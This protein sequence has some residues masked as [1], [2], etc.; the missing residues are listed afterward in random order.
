[1]LK[2]IFFT[3]IVSFSISAAANPIQDG[4]ASHGYTRINLSPTLTEV[5]DELATMASS[6]EPSIM[7]ETWNA[8]LRYQ[9]DK[10]GVSDAAVWLSVIRGPEVLD[11]HILSDAVPKLNRHTQPT[12]MGLARRSHEGR[13][14]AVLV[15]LHQGATF[16]VT[17]PPPSKS[18]GD[19]G[20]ITISGQLSLG[21]FQP[22]AVIETPTGQV[23]RQPLSVDEARRF[24]LV[25][26]P[27]TTSSSFRVEL[28]A[29]NVSGPRVLNVLRVGNP[30][31]APLL[32]IIRVGKSA[33]GPP[34]QALYERIERFRGRS[35]HGHLVY[36]ESLASVATAHARFLSERNAL[37]H[38]NHKGGHLRQRLHAAAIRPEFM[39]ELLVYAPSP[40]AAFGALTDSPAHLSEM[41]NHR[42]NRIGIGMVKN[43]YVV[44]LARLADEPR[45][46]D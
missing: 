2:L 13:T 26:R 46:V 31:T 33:D 10:R 34:T 16:H 25:W 37:V 4:L 7:S 43:F 15:L 28:V 42:V 44:V 39:S 36:D 11:A 20:E 1:M 45:K 17:R 6:A 35:G 29:E 27:K 3:S 24:S 12:A 8:H 5:A 41:K 32:P 40:L 19:I 21:Y 14:T 22:K 23:I 9:L 38:R 18:N 30:S